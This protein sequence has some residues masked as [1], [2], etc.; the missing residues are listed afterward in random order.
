MTR[1]TANFSPSLLQDAAWSPQER[2]AYTPSVTSSPCSTTS[3]VRSTTRLANYGAD[4]NRDFAVIAL[5][6][7]KLGREIEHEELRA[8][9]ANFTLV[10]S[11][12][13][14]IRQLALELASHTDG[15]SSGRYAPESPTGHTPREAQLPSPP[16]DG[17]ATPS[18][19]LRDDP[20]FFGPLRALRCNG[21]HLG[22][23]SHDPLARLQSPCSRPP[24]SPSRF[25]A[26]DS[27]A[28][29]TP[30]GSQRQL[31]PHWQQ[32][33]Q[34]SAASSP[35]PRL[36]SRLLDSELSFTAIAE[37]GVMEA[38]SVDL[39]S[40]Q[41]APRPFV[42]GLNLR[43]L[44][45]KVPTLRGGPSPPTANGSPEAHLPA[46]GPASSGGSGQRTPDSCSPT[47]ILRMLLP[48][49]CKPRPSA[50]AGA[51]ARIWSLHSQAGGSLPERAVADRAAAAAAAE[52]VALDA[53]DVRQ[54]GCLRVSMDDLDQH[55]TG[56]RRATPIK[57]MATEKATDVT[58]DLVR[59]KAATTPLVGGQEKQQR[60]TPG[61][62]ARRHRLQDQHDQQSDQAIG[63]VATGAAAVAA[64]AAAAALLHGSAKRQLLL[65]TEQPGAGAES[66]DRENCSPVD[67]DLRKDTPSKTAAAAGAATGTDAAATAACMAMGDA[68]VTVHCSRPDRSPVFGPP[69][70]SECRDAPQPQPQLQG[71]SQVP[72]LRLPGASATVP[73]PGAG[74]ARPSARYRAW[75]AP[76]GASHP[77][78]ATSARMPPLALGGGAQQQQH[79]H[80]RGQQGGAALPNGARTRRLSIC[81]PSAMVYGEGPFT[82]RR[83]AAGANTGVTSHAL[84]TVFWAESEE[85]LDAYDDS[86]SY[87][88][89][90]L[91]AVD[92]HTEYD[93]LLHGTV[94][95]GLLGADAVAAASQ[96]FIAA[97]AAALVSEPTPSGS[98]GA[99][100]LA[101]APAR[102]GGRRVRGR[103][104]GRGR[105]RDDESDDVDPDRCGG[106]LMLPEQLW[107][108]WERLSDGLKGRQYRL[109]ES[110]THVE[111][112]TCTSYS[113][114][115]KACHQG[116]PVVVKIYDVAERDKLANAFAEIGV[117]LH[118]SGWPG[119]VRLLDYGRHEDKVM[120][121]LESCDHS[122]KDWC[123]GQRFET[124][125]G[126]DY[127]LECLRLWCTLAELLTEL[128]ERWHVAHCDLKPGNV[129][130][131]AGQLRLAD[132]S[133]SMLFNE[134]PVL[135]DQARGTVPY[136][137][138]EMV[139]G[140]CVDARK[141]DVWAMG[142]ILY[143]M[144]TGELLFRGNS[145]CMRAVAA[146]RGGAAART[147]LR[148][149]PHRQRGARAP[150]PRPLRPNQ[151]QQ[152]GVVPSAAAAAQPPPIPRWD[153]IQ[154]TAEQA[155]LA[156]WEQGAATGAEGG[157]EVISDGA[158]AMPPP[159]RVPR[160]SLA[161]T[162]GSGVTSGSPWRG[163]PPSSGRSLPP[164]FFVGPGCGS[165]MATGRSL[166]LIAEA[167]GAED[168]SS[169]A[170]TDP[171]VAMSVLHTAP[172]TARSTARSQIPYHYEHHDTAR[173]VAST[174]TAAAAGSTACWPPA[175]PPSAGTARSVADS[176]WTLALPTGT[177]AAAAPLGYGGYGVSARSCAGAGP[178]SNRSAAGPYSGRG[179]GGDP[180]GLPAAAGAA[181]AA[182]PPAPAPSLLPPH[183]RLRHSVATQCADPAG[184]DWL[185]TEEA[186]RLR[187]MCDEP[188]S[189]VLVHYHGGGGGSSTAGAGAG[190][191]SEGGSE[192]GGMAAVA[193]G[194]RDLYEP[195]LLSGADGP[196]LCDDVLGLL[197]AV[198]VEDHARPSM[199]QVAVL[200]AEAMR[201]H[202][203]TP[204]L[205][206]EVSQ[207][208]MAVAADSRCLDSSPTNSAGVEDLGE[209]ALGGLGGA[210]AL[211]GGCAVEGVVTG[212]AVLAAAA[213]GAWYYGSPPAS[214]ARPTE[215]TQACRRVPALTLPAAAGGGGDAFGDSLMQGTAKLPPPPPLCLS[216]LQERP[217][218]CY[219]GSFN[220]ATAAAAGAAAAA[221]SG[222]GSAWGGPLTAGTDGG[223]WADTCSLSDL[224][225]AV[226]DLGGGGASAGGGGP[227]PGTAAA[228]ADGPADTDNGGSRSVSLFDVCQPLVTERG[229]RPFS[230][231]WQRFLTRL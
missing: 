29:C 88:M 21:T 222:G 207:E 104:G 141:A 60:A 123:D 7:D 47:E 129:L 188:P 210:L 34:H 132:F 57:A 39:I 209:S 81:L 130:L 173:S 50:H 10:H 111:R 110:L 208:G 72:P 13:P 17:S 116:N 145:D 217:S 54:L 11:Q 30:P 156:L 19:A 38:S 3:S 146:G 23:L 59:S 219:D 58:P 33:Q 152:R 56:L 43:V 101:P 113:T 20:I 172:T 205:S 106:G 127:I 185:T 162:H 200:A 195:R 218:S 223:S 142:C 213:H 119:A 147:R 120:L 64:G 86:D 176:E 68:V 206:S 35:V 45:K 115:S 6:E 168:A 1:F 199:R 228:A 28:R 98:P 48:S 103:R 166:E 171:W 214:S 211:A 32:Q 158:E 191:C 124:A 174:S 78:A 95:Y 197:R 42:P 220:S 224:D 37:D 55:Q 75:P 231:S 215:Q 186:D 87:D 150:P 92:E 134:T 16:N 160:L 178:S 128:H 193:A 89:D 25:C 117:L 151:P 149:Q 67:S 175:P 118:L 93:H 22:L 9:I 66:Y 202:C 163:Q 49:A 126:A 204:P 27:Q 187:I 73:V 221:S 136:Q 91:E 109:L 2:R 179:G 125:T 153:I 144:I 212:G 40:Q 12:L 70:A 77:P 18:A 229:P 194:L 159:P 63:R 133:E 26:L 181:A 180:D 41:P 51:P 14:S 148:Q 4:M 164:Q 62:R 183:R 65:G 31:E 94:E 182:E 184:P 69:A 227:A 97:A 76:A 122:L 135:Q 198:L 216:V 82:T 225:Q 74:A 155:A 100:Q 53:D 165:A 226:A 8:A 112:I 121:M 83:M 61:S 24:P 161:L 108:A 169:L 192:G 154:S 170:S 79:G 157:T 36:L 105:R 85:E 84:C 189:F 140:H 230:R 143:E 102:G 114:V 15:E 80:A 96:D 139:H 177:G 99:G 167:C 90:E 5:L 201:R 107:D 196:T 137:P 52:G 44:K 71:P 46:P 190:P 138:P 203:P 131:S